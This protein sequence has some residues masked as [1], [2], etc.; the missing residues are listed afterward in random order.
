MNN[1]HAV[2]C[3]IQDKCYK[4][5]IKPENKNEYGQIILPKDTYSAGYF[6]RISDGN[7]NNL[8]N[9]PIEYVKHP[10]YIFNNELFSCIDKNIQDIETDKICSIC[11]EN[12]KKNKYTKTPCNHL[13]CLDCITSWLSNHN[14]CP[15]CRYKL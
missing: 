5:Y 13:Y 6:E 12:L 11:H 7:W 9:L 15:Y 8:E 10:F 3:G 4:C 1:I 14:T 2:Y